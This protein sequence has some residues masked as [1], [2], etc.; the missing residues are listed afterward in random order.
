M[1]SVRIRAGTFALAVGMGLALSAATAFAEPTSWSRGT[2]DQSFTTTARNSA[3]GLT[4]SGRY[5][6]TDDPQSDPAFMEKMVFIPPAG[7]TFDTSVP[8]QCT[9]SDFELSMQGPAA[10]PE[11]SIIGGGTTEGVFFIPFT[12]RNAVLDRYVHNVYIANNANEQIILVEAEGY[13]VIRGKFLDDGSVEFASP[14]CFPTPP[15]GCLDDHVLQTA[16]DTAIPEYTRVVDRDTHSYAT[17][18]PTC[19]TAES[20]ETHVVFTWRDGTVDDVV[21]RQPCTG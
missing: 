9:A 13:A 17:T 3:T 5:H 8:E 20:W 18:P 1:G 16:S 4:F 15:T 11:G 19:P 14:T 12:Q 2:I 7:M 6:A 10:C 21:T